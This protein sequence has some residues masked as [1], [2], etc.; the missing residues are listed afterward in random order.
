MCTNI[1]R[2][3]FN[4]KAIFLCRENNQQSPCK[5]SE[6]TFKIFFCFL[7]GFE[8]IYIIILKICQSVGG[9]I[10][11]MPPLTVYG[12]KGFGIPVD[13]VSLSQIP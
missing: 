10:W 1:V 9:H 6:T 8:G 5:T 12:V 3:V 4:R 7:D 11:S 2:R 13:M